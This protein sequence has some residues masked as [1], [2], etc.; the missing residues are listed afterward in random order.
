MRRAFGGH[1]QVSSSGSAAILS[2]GANPCKQR[3]CVRRP[4]PFLRI[5]TPRDIS[6]HMRYT[7]A[8]N[9]FDTW[10]GVSMNKKTIA[11]TRKKAIATNL[12][13]VLL[14]GAPFALALFDYELREHIAEYLASK[15]ADNDRYFFAITEHTN[16]VAMLLIDE[17]DTIYINEDAR[18]KLRSLWGDAYQH[19]IELLLPKMVQD[20]NRGYLSSTGVQIA[21][22][23]QRAT[24]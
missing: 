15:H 7:L 18:A 24:E 16:D 3:S 10:R 4:S 11:H 20:L 8:S 17:Q 14:D 1:Y 19:N 23:G 2:S 9:H 5:Q 22:S 6:Q 12:R 13:R 21:E